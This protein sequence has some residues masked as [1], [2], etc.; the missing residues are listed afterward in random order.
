MQVIATAKGFFGALI[1]EG[2]TFD[3]PD[4]S[5]ASWFKPIGKG[6]EGT[7]ATSSKAGKSATTTANIDAIA[8]ATK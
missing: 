3:V 8:K 5:K 2:Q 6:E 1:E 7:P 4:G